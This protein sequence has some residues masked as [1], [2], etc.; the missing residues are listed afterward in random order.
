MKICLFK[1]IKVLFSYIFPCKSLMTMV[2]YGKA[3]N[4]PLQTGSH[5]ELKISHFNKQPP[6]YF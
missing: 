4:S 6:Q 3:F 5:S 2:N 1:S